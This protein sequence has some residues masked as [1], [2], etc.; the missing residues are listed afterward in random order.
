MFMPRTP[1]NSK[2]SLT[3][4]LPVLAKVAPARLLASNPKQSLAT[5]LENQQQKILENQQQQKMCVGVRRLRL[6][7]LFSVHAAASDASLDLRCV[8]QWIIDNLACAA[9]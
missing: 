8:L 7:M 6:R 2:Q 4:V 5:D 9:L 1:T 3:T